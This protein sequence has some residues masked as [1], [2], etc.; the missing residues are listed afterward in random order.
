M[1]IYTGA[2][3]TL[4]KKINI[5]PADIRFVWSSKIHFSADLESNQ[6]SQL[7]AID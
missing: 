2:F 7:I 3:F 4:N 1:G 5:H 6:L